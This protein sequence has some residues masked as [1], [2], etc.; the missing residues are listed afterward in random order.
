MVCVAAHGEPSDP[1]LEAAHSCGNGHLGCVTP[2]H[3]RWA[4][5]QQNNADRIA[6]PRNRFCGAT[7]L[8]ED[9]VRAIRADDRSRSEIADEYGITKGYVSLI[10]ARKVWKD[11]A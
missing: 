5:R 9:K 10:R 2:S 6:G 11:T 7:K 4:T 1:A 3:I 8:N